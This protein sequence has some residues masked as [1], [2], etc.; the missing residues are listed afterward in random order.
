MKRLR[1][2]AVTAVAV[3]CLGGFAAPASA[4]PVC[5]ADTICFDCS[6]ERLQHIWRKVF[7]SE[8]H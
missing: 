2:A 6:D 1:L 5:H 7:G 4:Q 8:C 3:A